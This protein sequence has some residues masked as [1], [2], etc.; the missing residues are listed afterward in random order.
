MRINLRSFDGITVAGQKGCGKTYLIQYLLPLYQRVFVFDPTEEFADYPRYIPKS[1]SPLELERIA[2]A[3]WNNGNCVL[4]VS[5][6][7][8]SLPVNRSLPPSI[9]KIVTRGRHR[10]IGMIADTRRIANLNKTVF[11]LSEWCFIFR[12]FS[13][14]DIDYLNKFLPR[15]AK[16]LRN[17]EDRYFWVYHRNRI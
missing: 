8:L 9:F 15:D 14:N 16:E 3:V 12:H 10:N 17:L 13:P 11:S 1:D 6:A 4:V 5:E 7:E 2:K